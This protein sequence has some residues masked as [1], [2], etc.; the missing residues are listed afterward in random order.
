MVSASCRSCAYSNHFSYA[1]EDKEYHQLGKSLLASSRLPNIEFQQRQLHTENHLVDS[2]QLVLLATRS[3]SI[4]DV[5][6]ADYCGTEYASSVLLEHISNL[7]LF[8][9]TIIMDPDSAL[10]ERAG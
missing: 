2:S 4:L 1:E 8:I 3:G 9:E 6:Y 5:L 7:Y 10:L